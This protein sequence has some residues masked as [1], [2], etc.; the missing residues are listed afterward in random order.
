MPHVLVFDQSGIAFD[1]W[2]SFTGGTSPSLEIRDFRREYAKRIYELV[3]KFNP[4]YSIFAI[5]SNK[6]YWRA[7][8]YDAWY[9]DHCEVGLDDAGHL[10]LSYDNAKY[11]ILQDGF[12]GGTIKVKPKKDS[13]LMGRCPEVWTSLGEFMTLPE[14]SEAHRKEADEHRPR[15]KGSR[16]KREWAYATTQE[17]WH[18][19]RTQ[20]AY[21]MALCIPSKVIEVDYAE[22]DDVAFEVADATKGEDSAT[23]VSADG[24]WNQLVSEQ[25]SR[26]DFQRDILHSEP[27]SKFGL[28]T[29][30]LGGDKSDCVAG[31]AIPGKSCCLAEAGAKKTLQEYEGNMGGLLAKA[32]EEGWF[33]HLKFNTTLM[34]LGKA[35]A[36]IR[37]RIV[38]ALEAA[39]SLP[40]KT[41]EIFGMTKQEIHRMR[42]QV[43]VL[44]G[45]SW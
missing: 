40:T 9:R 14:V 27:D 2:Y 1:R 32:K 29:K 34:Q 6:G 5:D 24:D 30:L 16:R 26:Y 3:L 22:A 20:T 21:E 43:A 42:L 31:V 8:V 28:R 39:P 19:V 4:D 44:R 13:E 10:W 36:D 15:Y 41:M 17:Q 12:S 35:P 11:A 18:E 23:L 7:K 37:T 38:E 45:G 33:E 25:V